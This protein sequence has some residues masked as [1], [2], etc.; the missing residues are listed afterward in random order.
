VFVSGSERSYSKDGEGEKASD[1]RGRKAHEGG[2][3]RGQGGDKRGND[4]G[5]IS[6]EKRDEMRQTLPLLERVVRERT[7]STLAPSVTMSRLPQ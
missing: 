7:E 6:N 2:G 5:E 3:L 1:E 4:Q